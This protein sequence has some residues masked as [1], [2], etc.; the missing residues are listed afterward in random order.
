MS[1][2]R[3]GTTVAAAA[4]PRRRLRGALAALAGLVVFAAG[5][6][7]SAVEASAVSTTPPTCPSHCG[8]AYYV[9]PT[10][11]DTNSGTSKSNPWKTVGRVNSAV[12]TAGSR[13]LFKGGS[14]FSD[15]ILGGNDGGRAG[16][17]IT[18]GSY[19]GG[20]AV[21]P[22]GVWVG[23]HD[24]V[25]K[26]FHEFLVFDNLTATGNGIG[27]RGNDITIKDSDIGNNDIAINAVF[28]SRWHVLNNYIHDTA[29][30][31]IIADNQGTLSYDWVIDGNI[32]IRTGTGDIAYGLHGIYLK[33]I[34]ATVTNNTITD[35]R[36]DGVSVRYGNSNVSHNTI[37]GGKAG[38]AWFQYDLVARTSTW[39]SNRIYDTDVG[40][41]VSSSDP[42]AGDTRESFVIKHNDIGPMRGGSTNYMF[43]ESITGTYKV[44]GNVF[45]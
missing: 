44:K 6:G 1:P 39:N 45:R 13:V 17:P 3:S 12:L 32:I 36:E 42:E 18:Y 20:N 40:I 9:S 21:L 4:H 35:F 19:G 5:V 31:G 15:A 38:I 34:N 2:K 41:G 10:G 37:S 27:G 43:L 16:A 22:Q 25:F 23:W 33:V 24:G 29:D 14:T 11:L 8:P 26:G 7:V 28:G 30:S